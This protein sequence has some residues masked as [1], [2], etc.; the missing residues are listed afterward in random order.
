MKLPGRLRSTTLGDLLGILHRARLSGVL[1]LREIRG[2]RAGVLHRVHLIDGNV[3][4]VESPVT[5]PSE[6]YAG[7]GLGLGVP[8]SRSSS[9][10]S[11]PPASPSHTSQAPSS[12]RPQR[13]IWAVLDRPGVQQ[14]LDELFQLDDAEIAFR[15]ARAKPA[16]SLRKPLEPVEFLHGRPRQRD[17]IS[18]RVAAAAAYDP[19]TSP[20]CDGEVHS[21]DR[22]TIPPDGSSP[23]S[24]RARALATLGL[25]A[26][27]T[28][29]EIQRAFRV[30]AYRFHPDRF[31]NAGPEEKQAIS[32]NFAELTRAYHT[33]QT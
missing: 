28:L 1:E 19:A 33:L 15:V 16:D 24:I 14:R 12:R 22:P 6:A 18:T 17:R 27:A 3:S 32:E 20:S 13:D 8:V 29:A 25:R 21:T 30:L 31:P 11:P 10:S 2:I 23:M 9:P 26:N 5:S 4:L 7:P